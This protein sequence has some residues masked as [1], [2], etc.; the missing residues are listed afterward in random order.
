MFDESLPELGFANKRL[1]LKLCP[2]RSQKSCLKY[3]LSILREYGNNKQI[4][5]RYVACNY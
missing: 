1:A 5:M 3:T 4:I 2:R